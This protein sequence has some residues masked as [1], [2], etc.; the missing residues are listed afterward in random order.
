MAAVM[1][2]GVFW[3]NRRGVPLYVAATIGLIAVRNHQEPAMPRIQTFNV[4][5]SVPSALAGLE[6]LAYDLSWTW[7]ADAERLFRRIDPACWE[8]VN[9]NPVALLGVVGQDVLDALSSDAAFLAHLER[10]TLA[11]AEERALPT[12]F[13]RQSAELKGVDALGDD[14]LVAY[15]C[16]EYGLS[17]ALPIYS[18]GLGVL[19]GD[20]LKSTTATGLPYV[21]VGLAY[22]EGYFRQYLN[23][24]GW[25][26]EDPYDN[27]FANLPIK[28]ACRPD[29]S[30]ATVDVNIEGRTVHVRIW[31]ATVGR[32][33]L[34]LL[35]TNSP[36]NTDEDR[37]ITYRLYGGGKEYR[38]KQEIVLGIGGYYAL[39]TLGLSP[40]VYH[41]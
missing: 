17:E 34:F 15:F 18:G 4:A 31:E 21:A 19:A 7:H 29:G 12:W 24:E 36:Q 1:H 16:A 20:T 3:V 37:A 39:Q 22:Q 6:T 5:P 10:V 2:H 33:R 28:R 13:G 30:L 35:D 26:Q 8:A 27:D 23:A 9:G 38:L 25:Q 32:T 41:M 11:V 14:F 40:T